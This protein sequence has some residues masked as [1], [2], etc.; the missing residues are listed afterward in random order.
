ML[1][2]MEI[3]KFMREKEEKIQTKFSEKKEEF[4]EAEIPIQQFNQNY[5]TVSMFKK[6]NA[7]RRKCVL[8]NK[9]QHK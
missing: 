6:K 5:L 9:T 7:L 1:Q 2:Y 3:T 8:R 4:S